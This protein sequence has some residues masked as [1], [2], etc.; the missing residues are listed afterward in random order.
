MNQKEPNKPKFYNRKDLP[1][2]ILAQVVLIWEKNGVPDDINNIVFTY[3]DGI[4]TARPIPQDLYIH[5]LTHFIRQGNGEDKEMAE[6]WW[7]QY[8][9]DPVFRYQ[10]ELMAYQEQYKWMKTRLNRPEAFKFAE[11]LSRELAS[12]KYG[13]D[14]SPNKALFEILK[15]NE[16]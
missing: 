4:Y 13:F 11:Y 10:E 9:S 6:R 1:D 5:E 3:F 7:K 16:K 12:K 14:I 15:V 8:C 2:H